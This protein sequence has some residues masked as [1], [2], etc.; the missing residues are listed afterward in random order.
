MR[1]L[2]GLCKGPPFLFNQTNYIKCAQEQAHNVLL[3]PHLKP[4][5]GGARL[6]PTGLFCE[7]LVCILTS[8]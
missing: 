7:P 4:K 5:M 2:E 8:V 3:L 6:F 1:F